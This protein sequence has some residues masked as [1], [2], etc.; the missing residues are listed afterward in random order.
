MDSKLRGVLPCVEA[1]STG[2]SVPLAGSMAKTVELYKGQA[3]AQE[4]VEF[5][6]AK[7]F[8]IFGFSNGFRHPISNRL[9]QADI[10]FI[11]QASL[12]SV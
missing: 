12:L 4:I 3:I 7:K 9:L 2:V 6:E 1:C 8:A 5:L 10:Y 11:R